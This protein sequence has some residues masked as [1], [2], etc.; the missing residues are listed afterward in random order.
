M[1]LTGIAISVLCKKSHSFRDVKKETSS[2]SP[3][4]ATGQ[5]VDEINVSTYARLG[6]GRASLTQ[7]RSKEIPV[8][9]QSTLALARRQ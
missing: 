1:A 6:A 3:S 2:V 7:L 8:F 5:R 9:S 4:R